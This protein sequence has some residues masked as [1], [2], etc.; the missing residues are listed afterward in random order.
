MPL[1][2][3]K[4]RDFLLVSVRFSVGTANRQVNFKTH[5]VAGE[6]STTVLGRKTVTAFFRRAASCHVQKAP[7]VE[8]DPLVAQTG[9]YSSEQDLEHCR[10][11]HSPKLASRRGFALWQERLA[12]RHLFPYVMLS[13]PHTGAYVKPHRIEFEE[14]S[15]QKNLNGWVWSSVFWISLVA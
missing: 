14:S 7:V 3:S 8:S 13:D 11:S 6:A 1:T 12:S 15:L 5:F 9:S 2:Q 4:K 10:K